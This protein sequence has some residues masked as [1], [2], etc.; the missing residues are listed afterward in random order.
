MMNVSVRRY[1][2][3]DYSRVTVLNSMR[4]PGGY[5]A[6]VFIRQASVLF[7]ATF[8]V[9]ERA[10]EV[11]GFI[12]GACEQGN[13]GNAWV[14][15]LGVEEASRRQQVGLRLITDLT[16]IFRSMQVHRVLLSVSPENSPA[17]RLYEK[18]GFEQKEYSNAYFGEGESRIIMHLEL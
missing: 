2:E 17:I 3:H 15:R 13:S 6:A 9:T 5:H 7:P 10:G 14:L 18:F 12:I 4:I 16:G 11:I 1:Q 8:L